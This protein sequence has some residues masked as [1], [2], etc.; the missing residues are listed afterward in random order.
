MKP[1]K[2]QKTNFTIDKTFPNV[3]NYMYL[4]KLLLKKTPKDIK[5]L[6]KFWYVGGKWGGGGIGVKYVY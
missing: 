4:G 1:K 5:N 2:T 6:C 3:S